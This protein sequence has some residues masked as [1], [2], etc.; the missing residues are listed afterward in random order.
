[1]KFY[2]LS[3]DKLDQILSSCGNSKLNITFKGVSLDE[4]SN[5]MYENH[6]NAINVLVSFAN[7]GKN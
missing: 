6:L 1:M 5:E 2:E 7:M 4:C 3:R